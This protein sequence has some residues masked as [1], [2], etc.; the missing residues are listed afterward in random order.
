[1]MLGEFRIDFDAGLLL[2]KCECPSREVVEDASAGG[3][4]CAILHSSFLLFSCQEGDPNHIFLGKSL[5][6]SWL[7]LCAQTSSKVMALP[8]CGA[9]LAGFQ[10]SPVAEK[11]PFSRGKCLMTLLW[12]VSGSQPG[13]KIR[14]RCWIYDL[15]HLPYPISN[16]VG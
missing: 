11:S 1:M 2:M 16:S 8:A 13:P 7:T 3:S 6:R 10:V 5:R 14:M 12:P 4:A 9:S 15:M